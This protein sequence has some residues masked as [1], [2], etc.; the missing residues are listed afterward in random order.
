MALKAAGEEELAFGPEFCI[1]PGMRPSPVTGLRADLVPHRQWGLCRWFYASDLWYY[2]RPGVAHEVRPDGKFYRLVDPDL[3]DLCRLLNEAGIRTTPSCQGHSYPRE[4]FEHIWSEL[5]KQQ[6]LIRGD[7]LVVK[8]CENDLPYVFREMSYRIPWP[9]FDAFYDEAG[10]HQN[11][12]YLGVLVPHHL[13]G[14]AQRLSDDHYTTRFTKLSADEDLSQ[15]FGLP[16]FEVLVNAMD[17][18]SRWAEWKA[19]TCYI[20]EIIRR[21][22]TDAVVGMLSDEC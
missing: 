15:I 14:I 3:R 19:F 13:P 10:A 17:P 11:L 8:D 22:E 1:D 18:Q 4:R 21:T 9:S 2:H 16:V 20:H 5:E 12:G 7:G 6:P